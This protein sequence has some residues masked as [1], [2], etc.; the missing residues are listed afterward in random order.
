MTQRQEYKD[1]MTRA[2]KVAALRH[3]V[4]A[5]VGGGVGLAARIFLLPAQAVYS[6]NGLTTLPNWHYWPA[7]AGFAVINVLIAALKGADK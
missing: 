2:I 4:T 3:T 5:I 6:W 1:A 7:V